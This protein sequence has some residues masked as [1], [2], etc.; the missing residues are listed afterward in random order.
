MPT[1]GSPAQRSLCVENATGLSLQRLS[2]L[3]SEVNHGHGVV[4]PEIG[5]SSTM[6]RIKR[7]A[8]AWLM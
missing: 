3:Q 7:Y 2:K 4:D 5:S 6:E 8:R 1:N